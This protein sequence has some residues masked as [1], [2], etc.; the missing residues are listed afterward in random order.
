MFVTVYVNRVTNAS[1]TQHIFAYTPTRKPTAIAPPYRGPGHPY[2]ETTQRDKEVRPRENAGPCHGKEHSGIRYDHSIAEK[3]EEKKLQ[4]AGRIEASWPSKAGPCT[5]LPI[6]LFFPSFF[7]WPYERVGQ[8]SPRARPIIWGRKQREQNRKKREGPPVPLLRS[9][10]GRWKVRKRT[11][12]AKAFLFF[13]S[14]S[15]PPTSFLRQGS[16]RGWKTR[17]CSPHPNKITHTALAT[18]AHYTTAGQRILG[19]GRTAISALL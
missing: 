13:S 14:S 8:W 3:E 1:Y 10:G 18:D 16:L 15:S 5:F 9:W 2:D 12:E 7:P 19:S 17:L 6:F 4:D 11:K